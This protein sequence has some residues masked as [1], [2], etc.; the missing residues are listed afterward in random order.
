MSTTPPPPPANPYAGAQLQP[1]NPQDEKLWATLIHL[2]PLVASFVGLPFLGPLIG[3]LVLR[4]R[5]PFVRWHTAQALNFQLTVLIG[6]VVSLLLAIVIIGFFM[7]IAVWVVSIVFMIIAAVA[8]NRGE[9][10]KYPM[11]IAFV[12]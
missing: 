12:S 3:Y 1:M 8:A 7:L 6:Y 10:Y 5:G 11:T 9:Y 4:D 2:S